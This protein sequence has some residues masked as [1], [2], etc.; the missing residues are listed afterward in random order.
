MLVAGIERH[1]GVGMKCNI[2]GGDSASVRN[3]EIPMARITLRAHVDC[4]G[5]SEYRYVTR[6][7]VEDAA[8]RQA[9][10]AM[11]ELVQLTESYGGYDL[12]KPE[13]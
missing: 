11:L 10:E 9:K 4:G 13:K 3:I 1:Y 12:E 7:D 5:H 6:E 2:C 8:R